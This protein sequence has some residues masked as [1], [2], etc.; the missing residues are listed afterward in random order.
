MARGRSSG[1]ILILFQCAVP[2]VGTFV[3]VALGRE[4]TMDRFASVC[5]GV[6]LASVLVP[7]HPRSDYGEVIGHAEWAVY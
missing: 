5:L 6:D 1:K 3:Q 4:A 7:H 2:V